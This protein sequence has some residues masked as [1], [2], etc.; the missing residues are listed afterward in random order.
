MPTKQSNSPRRKAKQERSRET[1]DVVIKA[2]AQVLLR[3][4][5]ARASTNRIADTAGVSVGT[6]YQYFGDKNEIFD[7]LLQ[8]EADRVVGTLS[9]VTPDPALSLEQAIRGMLKLGFQLQPHGPE[10]YRYLEYMPN[11][12]FRRRIN[13]INEELA[14]FVRRLLEPHR[15]RLR[16]DDLE[17]A[18]FIVVQTAEGIGFNATQEMFNERLVD[19]VSDLLLRY[20]LDNPE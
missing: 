5:Y 17:L 11:G 9:A 6:I 14:G 7:A 13:R 19:E 8:R 15:E 20:L 18:S 4:G 12:L 16:V 3:E 1:I 2:A 10:L